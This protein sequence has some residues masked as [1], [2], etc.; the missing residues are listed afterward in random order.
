MSMGTIA[1]IDSSFKGGKEIL[2]RW[3]TEDAASV[4]RAEAIFTEEAARS[5]GLMVVCDL[6]TDLSGTAVRKFDPEARE[7]L[8][9]GRYAGG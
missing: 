7:I 4:A 5:H 2:A 9:P 1:R 3:D 8:S 6:G